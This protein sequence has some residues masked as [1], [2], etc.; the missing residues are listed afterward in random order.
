LPRYYLHIRSADGTAAIDEEGTDL[1]GLDAARGE[2]QAAAR[3]LFA[4]AIT[5]ARDPMLKSIVITDETG[6]EL[7][8]VRIKD[9][10]P[11]SFWD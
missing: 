1:A 4:A 2:A 7:G 10:L 9:L 3:E 5:L 6:K 8:E 11:P